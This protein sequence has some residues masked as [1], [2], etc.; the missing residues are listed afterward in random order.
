MS[1]ICLVYTVASK[2]GG[3]K[4]PRVKLMAFRFHSEYQKH[5]LDSQSKKTI[6]VSLFDAKK[7]TFSAFLTV[8]PGSLILKANGQMYF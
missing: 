1:K 2:Y 3:G 7:K 8:I 6:K 5:T 4:I